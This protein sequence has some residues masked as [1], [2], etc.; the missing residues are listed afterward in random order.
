MSWYD[1]LLNPVGTLNEKIVES[2]LGDF[3]PGVGDARAQEKANE[4][5]IK[6]DKLNRKWQE[7]MSNSAYQ[8]ATA[9]MKKAGLNPMLAFQQG[10]ASTPST[11]AAQV[12][13]ATKSALGAT[14]LQAYTGISAAHTQQ[15]QANTAQASAET[16]I[17]LQA[18]QTAETV[19]NT[20][21][22]NAETHLTAEKIKSEKTR[23]EIQKRDLPR[24]QLEHDVS[25]F[26]S[27]SLRKIEQSMFKNSAKP[28]E[29]PWQKTKN[30][31]KNAFKSMFE[32]NKQKE[33][34]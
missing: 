11:S 27:D 34:K 29:T 18:A 6:L 4:H 1:P 2:P 23:R 21:K 16:N 19:T 12:G 5:N 14:A 9:D 26:T 15:Q 17:A 10:G 33:K 22:A 8:R 13:S 32:L 7:R 25:Q 3:L 24:A 28:H 31:A 20:A 30:A